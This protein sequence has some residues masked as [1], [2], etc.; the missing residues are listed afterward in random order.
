MTSISDVSLTKLKSWADIL[1]V[2]VL[3]QPGTK[4]KNKAQYVDAITPVWVGVN[5]GALSSNINNV[6]KGMQKQSGFNLKSNMDVKGNNNGKT[7]K[8]CKPQERKRTNRN[9]TKSDNL[10]RRT[11]TSVSSLRRVYGTPPKLS[12]RDHGNSIRPVSYTHLTLPTKA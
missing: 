11:N 3:Y 10:T 7:S 8:R 1:D 2:N 12:K 6:S 5:G 9:V 4:R